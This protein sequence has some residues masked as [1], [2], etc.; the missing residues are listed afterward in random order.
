[1]DLSG[2][3]NHARQSVNDFQPILN[4]NSIEFDGLNDYLIS[5]TNE[6]ISEATLVAVT[7]LGSIPFSLSSHSG[8]GVISI[9]EK[10]SNN[11]DAIAYNELSDTRKK[12]LHSS[13]NH[14]RFYGSKN[15]ITTTGPYIL[16]DQLK[17]NNFKQFTNGELTA[18]ASYTVVNKPEADLSLLNNTLIQAQGLSKM[19]FGLEST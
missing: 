8:G 12:F 16:F 15:E 17:T 1:M 3:Q 5:R 2:N 4:N 19:G 9:Q 11:F 14:D 7:T 13:T 10:N 6:S 18:S